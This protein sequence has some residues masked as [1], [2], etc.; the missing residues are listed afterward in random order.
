MVPALVDSEPPLDRDASGF[1]GGILVTQRSPEEQMQSMLLSVEADEEMEEAFGKRRSGT[2]LTLVSLLVIL[3]SV[4]VIYWVVQQ[5]QAA[6][7][8][9]AAGEDVGAAGA[10]VEAGSGTGAGTEAESESESETG[11]ETEAEAETGSQ[12]ESESDPGF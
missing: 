4:G 8:G 3:G 1:G 11:S 7:T 9:Q 10:E 6:P 2:V 5:R 12:S